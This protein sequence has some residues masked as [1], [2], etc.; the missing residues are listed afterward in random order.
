LNKAAPFRFAFLSAFSVPRLKA[1]PPFGRTLSFPES[2]T[3]LCKVRTPS[4]RQAVVPF[5]SLPPVAEG[6]GLLL[7]GKKA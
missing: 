6:E 7:T 1:P 2:A 4:P 3:R 5:R